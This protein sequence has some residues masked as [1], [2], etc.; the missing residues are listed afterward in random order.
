MSE[1][2]TNAWYPLFAVAVASIFALMTFGYT[3]SNPI[4]KDAA[5]NTRA[6]YHL[7][8]AGVISSRQAGERSA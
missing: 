6:A 1:R 5:Q 7:V 2:L 8:H 4:Q 3:T